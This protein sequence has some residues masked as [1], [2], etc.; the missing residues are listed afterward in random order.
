ME[1]VIQKFNS[2]LNAPDDRL[3][4]WAQAKLQ[5]IGGQP[6]IRLRFPDTL[7]HGL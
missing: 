2:P 1:R 7:P 6:L 3:R 4:T 5:K